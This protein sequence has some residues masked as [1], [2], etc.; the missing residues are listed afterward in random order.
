MITIL[1][2]TTKLSFRIMTNPF[3]NW[4]FYSVSVHGEVEQSSQS[5]L[6]LILDLAKERAGPSVI[7]HIVGDNY[8]SLLCNTESNARRGSRFVHLRIYDRKDMR[9][10]HSMPN[11]QM[12]RFINLSG[13][14]GLFR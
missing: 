12:D 6:S 4:F 13:R 14:K 7:H 10:Q 5:T 9:I 8:N 11:K 2:C 1:F 3:N